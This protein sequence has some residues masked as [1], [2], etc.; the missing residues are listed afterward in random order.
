MHKL[1]LGLYAKFRPI[2]LPP[3]MLLCLLLGTLLTL[4]L[5]LR[6]PACVSCPPHWSS[7][8][9]LSV[10]RPPHIYLLVLSGPVV[11]SVGSHVLG[12]ILIFLPNK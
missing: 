11:F 1:D 10:L 3:Q 7:P 9:H 4:R 6:L 8:H 5:H 2:F 12:L